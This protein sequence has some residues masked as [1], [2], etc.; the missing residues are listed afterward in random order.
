MDSH[1]LPSLRY[2][3]FYL[4]NFNRTFI[5]DW[6]RVIVVRSQHCIVWLLVAVLNITI[7]TMLHYIFSACE[8]IGLLICCCRE[9]TFVPETMLLRRTMVDGKNHLSRNGPVFYNA[10]YDAHLAAWRWNKEHQSC[11]SFPFFVIQCL[12]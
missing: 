4:S 12:D 1:S 5:L 11:L 3:I 9:A 2:F 8:S 6:I 10:M 7:S